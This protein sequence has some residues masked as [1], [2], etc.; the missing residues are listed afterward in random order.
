MS[1][2]TVR[3]CLSEFR[4]VRCDDTER[5]LYTWEVFK[6]KHRKTTSRNQTQ[7]VWSNGVRYQC[8]NIAP[9]VSSISVTQ[10][11]SSDQNQTDTGFLLNFFLRCSFLFSRLSAAF[12][13]I[14]VWLRLNLLTTHKH[15]DHQPI[16]SEHPSLCLIHPANQNPPRL[17]A[18]PCSATQS[19]LSASIFH[20]GTFHNSQLPLTLSLK[21]QS[22][23]SVLL[24]VLLFLALV[25]C[26]F[27]LFLAAFHDDLLQSK[28]D[29]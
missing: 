1:N 18:F 10:Q 2:I 17:S 13:T 11:Q 20:S 6:S 5:V 7:Q 4:E 15:H 12:Y 22:T 26:S 14:T 29:K 25:L 24:S 27:L 9:A 21:N 23:L 28:S 19:N 16:V 3:A 8:V